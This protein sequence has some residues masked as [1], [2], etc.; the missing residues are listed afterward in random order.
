MSVYPEHDWIIWKFVYVPK[1]FWENIENQRK[2]FDWLAKELNVKQPDDWYKVTLS[3]VD[4][5]HGSGV[6]DYYSGSLIKALS[7]VYPHHSWQEKRVPNGYWNNE[8]NVI[9]FLEE[10]R[11]ELG[12]KVME[13]WYSISAQHLIKLGGTTI[14]SNHGGFFPLLT[15]FYP[16]HNWN[17]IKHTVNKTQ[18]FLFNVVKSFFPNME[19]RANYKHPNLLFTKTSQEMELDV[20][21]DDLGL[22]FEYQGEQHYSSHYIYGSP[23][24]V[25]RRDKEKIE[26]CNN[27]QITL[28]VV[29]FWWDLK[30]SSLAATI[31]QHRPDLQKY[32]KEEVLTWH[33]NSQ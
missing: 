8:Q 1:K 19:V 15:R 29:P 21:I 32:F 9:Q 6:L 11:K 30:R 23:L 13:D 10:V 27:N 26:A 25:Q 7:F 28:I 22:A 16:N 17:M 24:L 12:I 2:Y 3:H 4:E 20:Y 18:G 31:C 33:T 14:L 5:F